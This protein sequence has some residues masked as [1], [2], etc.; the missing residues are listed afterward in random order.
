MMIVLSSPPASLPPSIPATRDFTSI[1]M[2]WVMPSVT[3]E[4][5]VM[6]SSSSLALFPSPY[7]VILSLAV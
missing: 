7:M 1:P 3:W 2:L 6:I 5:P 4:V